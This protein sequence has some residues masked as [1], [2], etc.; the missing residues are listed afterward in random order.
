MRTSLLPAF[1]LTSTH[2]AV[3]HSEQARLPHTHHL[4]LGIAYSDLL[5]EVAAFPARCGSLRMELTVWASLPFV[6]SP[7]SG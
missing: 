3:V 7:L 4:T 5:L 2:A 6:T 1:H